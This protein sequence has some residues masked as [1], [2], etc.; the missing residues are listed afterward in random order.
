MWNKLLH[1][2]DNTRRVFSAL[3]FLSIIAA[4]VVA[5]MAVR[6]SVPNQAVLVLD[7]NGPLVEELAEPGAGFPLGLPT[8]AQTRM[9]DLVRVIHAARDDKRIRMILLDLKNMDRAPLTKLQTLRR[10]IDDFK[11]SGKK[12]V[13]AADSYTQSQYYLAASADTVYLHP[14]GMVLLTGLSLYRNYFKD[15]LDKMKVNIHL[16]RAGEFKS[17]AEPLVRNDMSAAARKADRA[18]LMQLWNSYKQNIANMRRI[19]ADDI[20]NLLDHPVS[21]VQKYGGSLAQ[22]ALKMRLVDKLATHAEVKAAIARQLGLAGT[23]ALPAISFKQYLRALGPEDKPDGNRQIGLIVASGDIL[24]GD[25]PP[26]AIGGDSF[27]KLVDMARNDNAIKAVVL[28]IDSPGGSAMASET[29]RQAI[30]RLKQAGK[31]VVVSMGSMAASGGYWIASAADEIWAAPA[32]LTGSI[33]VFGLFP[34]FDQGLNALGIHTDGLGTTQIAGGM[35]TDRPLN[36]KLAKVLQMS[37]NHVYGDFISHVAQGRNLDAAKVRTLAKGR[38]WTGADALHLG[39]VDKLGTLDGA[40]AAA[41]EHA[42]LGKNYQM[43][44]I[45]PKLGVRE[46][47]MEYLMGEARIIMDR[48]FPET[49]AMIPESWRAGLKAF[50]LTRLIKLSG[51]IYAWCEM[52]A[53]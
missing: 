25:Q 53:I 3:I 8:V 52:P 48:A 16:F 39:L 41:A 1:I 28:R 17:A 44:R 7:P 43:K 18:L 5:V 32:T 38:V 33:G 9:R 2:L 15:A 46:L 24:D 37:V 4:L 31:P 27:S 49:L 45:Q 42:K 36:P 29:I 34:G 23:A 14:M 50:E 19:K 51:G 21:H 47:I 12:V 13:A 30:E 11:T 20:Q 40:I 35:R 26:G 6:P 22:L 10:A